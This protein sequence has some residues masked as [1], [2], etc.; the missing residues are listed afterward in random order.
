MSCKLYAN[1]GIGHEN[2]IE[3]LK[4]RVINAAQC[5]ADA[6]VINKT[7]PIKL[8]PEEKNTGFFMVQL[9]S[10]CDILEALHKLAD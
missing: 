7:T 5:N 3:V 9:W 10:S 6:V 8:I 2:D 4:T 1:I